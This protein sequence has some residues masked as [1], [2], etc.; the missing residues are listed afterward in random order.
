LALENATSIASTLVTAEA[1][2]VDKPEPEGKKSSASSES[3]Y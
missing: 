2:I 1:I 3:M